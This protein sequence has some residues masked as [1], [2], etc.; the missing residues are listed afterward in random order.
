MNGNAIAKLEATRQVQ[1]GV[2]V[3][4]SAD[5]ANIE[6][7]LKLAMAN[8]GAVERPEGQRR[9]VSEHLELLKA[10]T[11]R[12]KFRLRRWPGMK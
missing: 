6:K 3:T 2:C 1:Y 12:P 9:S 5:K 10:K 7:D 4:D 8:R 11:P